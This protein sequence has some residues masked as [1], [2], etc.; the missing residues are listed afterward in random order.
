[1]IDKILKVCREVKPRSKYDVYLSL[2]E[3]VGELATELAVMSGYSNKPEGKDGVIGE[4]VDIIICAVDM[5]YKANSHLS[6]KEIENL[7]K[8]KLKKWRENKS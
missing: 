6:S 8:R 7:I 5:I 3:E 4:S 1:M 2:S